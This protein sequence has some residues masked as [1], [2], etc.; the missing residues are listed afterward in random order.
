M[1]S[2]QD[3]AA[4]STDYTPNT[5]DYFSATNTVNN[6]QQFTDPN[7]YSNGIAEQSAVQP[8][9]QQYSQPEQYTQ[10]GEYSQSGQFND[11]TGYHDTNTYQ[12]TTVREPDQA[13]S[14]MT[15]EYEPDGEELFGESPVKAPPY[16]HEDRDY[17]RKGGEYPGDKTQTNFDQMDPVELYKTPEQQRIDGFEY[18]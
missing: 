4:Y 17:L 13:S 7:V 1:F 10:S 11:F 9:N 16:P 2:G 14:V 6:S 5:Q 8:S 12:P 15:E 3:N 18:Y